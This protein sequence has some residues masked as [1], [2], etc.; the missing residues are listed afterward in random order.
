MVLD[1]QKISVTES[2]L[3]SHVTLMHFMIAV[4]CFQYQNGTLEVSWVLMDEDR[5]SCKT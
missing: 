1:Q 5:L 3:Q 2:E 4:H